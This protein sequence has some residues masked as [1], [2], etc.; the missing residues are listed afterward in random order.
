[1]SPFAS[2]WGGGWEV[3]LGVGGCKVGVRVP[4]RDTPILIRADVAVRRISKNRPQR[5]FESVFLERQVRDDSWI[6]I[7]ADE[8]VRNAPP[9]PSRGTPSSSWQDGWLSGWQDGWKIFLKSPAGSLAGKM[10]GWLAGWVENIFKKLLHSLLNCIPLHQLENQRINIEPSCKW[11]ACNVF[12]W[13]IHKSG[14]VLMQCVYIGW[15]CQASLGPPNYSNGRADQFH[16]P[17]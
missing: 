11:S 14:S 16:P 2:S 7:K 8:S 13:Q 12:A 9:S 17:N 6:L 4:R 5:L 1:M 15:I 10:A 3:F